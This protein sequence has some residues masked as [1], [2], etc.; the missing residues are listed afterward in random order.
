MLD[1][2]KPLEEGL[3]SKKADKKIVSEAL[4]VTN[5]IRWGNIEQAQ[6]IAAELANLP[7]LPPIPGLVLNEVGAIRWMRVLHAVA[8]KHNVDASE[9]LGISRKR[10][11]INA[12]FEVFY[13]LRVDLL[14]SYQK[15]AHIMKKDHST[16]M[17]GVSKI[18]YRLLDDLKKK[19]DDGDLHSGNHLTECGN[20]HPVSEVLAV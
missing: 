11:V 15:I 12:R 9:I 20:T 14:M 2:S 6:R 10:H 7:R 5:P 18:R 3:V 16:V 13:R 19:G 17:H 1:L 4:D 8:K